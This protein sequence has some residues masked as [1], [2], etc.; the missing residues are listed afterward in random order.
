MNRPPR[1]LAAAL[2]ASFVVSTTG[3]AVAY[4]PRIA[5]FRPGYE[6]TRLG[7]DTYQVRIGEAW[8]K[9]WDDMEKF[10]MYRAAD[11]TQERGSRFFVVTKGGASTSTYQV[12]L[13]STSTTQSTVTSQGPGWATMNSATQGYQPQPVTFS[14]GWYVLEFRIVPEAAAGAVDSQQV[15]RD[16]GV[17][18]AGRS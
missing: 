18:I 5:G 8:P 12:A 14:G 16:L 11:I 10:A 6:Q 15:K 9:D 13:P 2:A 17:F 1:L 3:C 4:A 7:Q